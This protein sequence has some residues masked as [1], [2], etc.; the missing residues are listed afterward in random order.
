MNK[1]KITAA[2]MLIALSSSTVAFASGKTLD[3]DSSI[4]ST[5]VNSYKIKSIDISIKQAQNT[6]DSDMKK[7]A[8]YGDQLDEPNLDKY[9][10]LSLMQGIAN[11]PK[12]DKFNEYKYTKMKS[13]AENEVKLSAYN[14]YT[15]LVD[16]KDALDL[17][18]Q[19]FDNA[20]DKYNSA[21]VKLEIGTISPAQ[22]KQ[23]EAEYY[24]QKS[25]LDSAQR[26]YD[27]DVVNMNK[28]LGVDLS[29]KYDVLLRDKL[30]ED[31]YIRSYKEYLNDALSKRTEIVVGQENVKLQ[32]FEYEV[33][34]GVFPDKQSVPNRLAKAKWDNA[35]DS[36]EIQKA[37]ITSEVNS[38]Y[39]DLQ[40]K[41][42]TLNSKKDALELDKK[43]YNTALL[44][45]N[46]GV[47][48][49]LDLEDEAIKLKTSQNTLKSAER[50]IWLAQYKLGQACDIG[51]DT[52]KIN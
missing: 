29:E 10:I 14:Q 18:K 49:K 9:T 6:Y 27:M 31:P 47:L 42:K 33:A 48:S 1:L 5:I 7:T 20:K 40:I 50:D 41:V 2:A 28:T 19:K 13:V 30:T 39:N 24:S 35:I 26:A 23:A 43:N 21:K 38:L 52:S 34:D 8:D 15:G 4:D 12:E 17:A 46:V 11:P 32:K 3:I 51:Y 37:N 16:D 22:Q 45:Y 36:V 44:K 25:L